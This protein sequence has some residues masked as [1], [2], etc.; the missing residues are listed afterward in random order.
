MGESP[1]ESSEFTS[2]LLSMRNLMTARLPVTQQRCSAEKPSCHTRT[3]A[4]RESAT[5]VN[6]SNRRA[7]NERSAVRR[8]SR[9]GAATG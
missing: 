4:Q 5:Q 2:A 9:G 8:D 3:H 7:E 1:Y 6:Y